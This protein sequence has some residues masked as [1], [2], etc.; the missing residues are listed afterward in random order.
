[1]AQFNYLLNAS[2]VHLTSP[3]TPT[4]PGNFSSVS[5][6]DVEVGSCE[7]PANLWKKPKSHEAALK[8]E[9]VYS[10]VPLADFQPDWLGLHKLGKKAP[11]LGM[12]RTPEV[13]CQKKPEGDVSVHLV[14]EQPALGRWRSS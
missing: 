6:G 12:K 3:H 5:S 9:K 13:S 2:L 10:S 4:S 7:S 11:G 1:M 8:V 14:P